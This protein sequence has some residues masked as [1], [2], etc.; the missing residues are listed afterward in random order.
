M[1]S[2]LDLCCGMGGWSIG[3]YRAGFE[4]T[5]VDTLDIGYPYHLVQADVRSWH[6]NGGGMLTW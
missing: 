6:P 4:C 3:F 2:I 5:G 1:P